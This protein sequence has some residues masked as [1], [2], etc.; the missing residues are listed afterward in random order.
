MLACSLLPPAVWNIRQPPSWLTGS[1]W[2]SWRIPDL[3]PQWWESR[4]TCALSSSA[5]CC[6]LY[7]WIGWRKTRVFRDAKLFNKRLASRATR[8]CGPPSPENAP[9]TTEWAVF[10]LR[11]AGSSVLKRSQLEL[12][13]KTGTHRILGRK[14][15]LMKAQGKPYLIH[16]RLN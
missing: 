13:G 3:S 6:G 11:K 9:A 8:H 2:Y 7:V 5:W 15:W 14:L 1:P 16:W 10:S 4:A 12:F